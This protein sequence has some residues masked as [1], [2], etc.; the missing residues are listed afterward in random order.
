[1]RADW[2]PRDKTRETKDA[3]R[4]ATSKS[5]KNGED[6]VKQGRERDAKPALA[7]RPKASLRFSLPEFWLLVGFST[8]TR[9]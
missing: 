7:F 1:M 8:E 2:M 4:K 9:P 3:G 6:R 5:N